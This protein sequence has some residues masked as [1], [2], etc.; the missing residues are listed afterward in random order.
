M[1]LQRDWYKHSGQSSQLIG[2]D[3]IQH[4][5]TNNINTEDNQVSRF[6]IALPVLL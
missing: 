5:I 2:H 1:W 3:R 4:F 6:I